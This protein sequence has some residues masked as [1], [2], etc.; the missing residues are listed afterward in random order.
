[1]VPICDKNTPLPVCNDINY[2]VSKAKNNDVRYVKVYKSLYNR[3][4]NSL[5]RKNKKKYLFKKKQRRKYHVSSNKLASIARARA[6]ITMNGT[7][8]NSLQMIEPLIQ[9]AFCVE[10]GIDYTKEDVRNKSCSASTYRRLIRD[11]AG[12][13]I[14]Q[15]IDDLKSNPNVYIS[16]DKGTSEKKGKLNAT[17]PKI[18][19]WYNPKSKAIEEILL[20]VELAGSES[21]CAA[22]AI[23][24]SL[25][26]IIE[27]SDNKLN[28]TILGVFTDS[29]GG[30]TL[31]PL[32]EELSL[33]LDHHPHITIHKNATV[34]S[35]SLHNL[36]SCVRNMVQVVFDE[37]GTHKIHDK[38]EF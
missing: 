30:G 33:A 2:D 36:Q 1:M 11:Q 27:L 10:N 35:C 8:I 4:H 12:L 3:M 6:A 23:A 24:H 7:S 5:K 21:E 16:C 26:R 29:G 22:K 34:I 28:L 38:E 25:N 32:L 37:G 20:D 9:Y 19:T 15:I 13:T 31:Q 14:Y 17:F 18:L